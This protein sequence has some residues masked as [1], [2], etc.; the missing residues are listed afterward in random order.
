[1]PTVGERLRQA[2]EKA[3]LTLLDV[4]NKTKIQ[5]WILAHIER[6]DL[7][8]VPGGIFVRGYIMSF[9]QAVGLDGQ[10]VWREYR[11]ENPLPVA[12]PEPIPH[13]TPAPGAVSRWKIVGVAAALLAVVVAWRVMP[14]SIPDTTAPATN[15]PQTHVAEVVPA[16]APT[17][18]RDPE[19]VAAIEAAESAPATSPANS[20][21]V[22]VHTTAE[23]W[24][25]AKADGE[26][27]VYRL[28][29]PNEDLSI[30][31][32][33]QVF[34]RVGDASAV[35][36]TIN[37]LPGRPLGGPGVVRDVVVAPDSYQTLIAQ[38]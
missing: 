22:K 36:F 5:L 13:M 20:L 15:R 24:L 38:N 29:A 21:A 7:S 32:M 17:A 27:R 33:N 35:T 30:D 25:E 9:A 4:A 18:G 28:F 37:G 12:E 31:A 19:P 16:A 26:Q 14:R 6:D 23:V 3:G 34:L 1:M 2:R 10:C 11:A 8:R